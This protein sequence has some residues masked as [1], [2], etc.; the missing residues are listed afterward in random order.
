MK[1]LTIYRGIAL[2]EEESVNTENLGCAWSLCSVYAEQHGK[3]IAKA[4]GKDGWVVLVTTISE[5]FIDWSNTLWA[6]ETRPNEYEVVLN[7]AE[8]STEVYYSNLESV[9]QWEAFIGTSTSESE[10]EDYN[11]NY[12]GS[13]TKGDFFAL[14]EEF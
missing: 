12:D 5:D 13:L 2:N 11:D 1:S 9:E 7:G 4:Q 8:V 10:F 14:S 6:M 3:M